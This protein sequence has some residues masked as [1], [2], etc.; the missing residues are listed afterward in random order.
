MLRPS[1]HPTDVCYLILKNKFMKKN[2][3]TGSFCIKTTY[4]KLF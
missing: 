4:G 3:L 1:T 2:H